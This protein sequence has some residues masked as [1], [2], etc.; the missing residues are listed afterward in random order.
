MTLWPAAT[1]ACLGD[2]DPDAPLG[3]GSRQTLGGR[4]PKVEEQPFMWL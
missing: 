2:R 3:D 1:G 4:D